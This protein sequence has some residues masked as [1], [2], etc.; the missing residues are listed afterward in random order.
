MTKTSFVYVTYIAAEQEKVW[1]ALIDP[2]F[3]RKYWGY[4]N[5]SEW[6]P[7]SRWEHRRADG[8]G[9]VLLVGEVVE[10]TP[11]RRLVLTW[12]TPADAANPE[13]RSVVTLDLAMVEGMVRLVWND[14][15]SKH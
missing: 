9:T 6:K 8:S 13:A 14:A 11:P 3:T 10:F 4:D 7:G 1:R 15:R 5:V 2:E 12:G